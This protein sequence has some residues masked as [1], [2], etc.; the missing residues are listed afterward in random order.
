MQFS[1]KKSPSAKKVQCNKVNTEIFRQDDTEKFFGNNF[2]IFVERH[3]NTT[4]SRKRVHFFSTDN[5]NTITR[6]SK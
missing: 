1:L 2:F 5:Y 6:Y 4:Q 3:V